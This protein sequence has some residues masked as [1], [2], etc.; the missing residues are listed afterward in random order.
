MIV[1]IGILIFKKDVVDKL[2]M[3]LSNNYF[4][5]LNL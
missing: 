2:F 3:Y 1:N 4:K 5:N